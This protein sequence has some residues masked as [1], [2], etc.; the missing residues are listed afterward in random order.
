[1]LENWSHNLNTESILDTKCI[2]QMADVWSTSSSLFA[3]LGIQFK[4][5]KRGVEI[6]C[7]LN[8]SLQSTIFDTKNRIKEEEEEKIIK[9]SCEE[10]SSLVEKSTDKREWKIENCA[11]NEKVCMKLFILKIFLHS[12][13]E[14]VTSTTLEVQMKRKRMENMRKLYRKCNEKGDEVCI[15]V[16]P[17]HFE[18]S[19]CFVAIGTVGTELTWE[20]QF[21]FSFS[22]SYISNIIWNRRVLLLIEDQKKNDSTNI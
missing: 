8:P 3:I 20:L 1:M 18:E 14:V 12:F 2:L 9:F 19:S 22:T 16:S 4:L 17:L 5:L 10:C 13:N 7:K 11:R 15:F 6:G 21:N